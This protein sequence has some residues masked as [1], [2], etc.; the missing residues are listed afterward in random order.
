MVHC[1]I[2]LSCFLSPVYFGAGQP[3]ATQQNQKWCPHY[4]LCINCHIHTSPETYQWPLQACSCWIREMEGE[5]GRECASKWLILD[6]RG[7]KLGSER[8]EGDK[9]TPHPKPSRIYY[10]SGHSCCQML[11]AKE[12]NSDWNRGVIWVNKLER[13]LGGRIDALEAFASS[14]VKADS[15]D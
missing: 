10:K 6:L 14:K 13:G 4:E 12:T 9:L 3:G 1:M 8:R 11:M 5:R 7:P 15:S 2:S